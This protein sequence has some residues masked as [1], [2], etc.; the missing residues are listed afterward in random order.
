M[1][2]GGRRR[3]ISPVQASFA[4]PRS[5]AVLRSSSRSHPLTALTL[6]GILRRSW[7]LLRVT[8]ASRVRLSSTRLTVS[9]PSRAEESIPSSP[10]CGRTGRLHPTLM[11][12]MRS[13][14]IC[15][16]PS[17][18]R[19]SKTVSTRSNPTRHSLT[20][21]A[22]SLFLRTMAR[23]SRS[24]GLIWRSAACSASR[25][26]LCAQGWAPSWSRWAVFSGIR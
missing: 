17:F 13:V 21:T 1:S 10:L 9:L 6:S 3:R 26:R 22:G 18:L 16:T 23:V 2:L 12:R 15:R 20:M 19:S 7:P 8:T 14:T 5:L 24:A 4:S 11:G 25:V